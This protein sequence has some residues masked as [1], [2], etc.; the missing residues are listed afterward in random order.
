MDQLIQLKG[1]SL[2]QDCQ[3]RSGRESNQETGNRKFGLMSFEISTQKPEKDLIDLHTFGNLFFQRRLTF[4]NKNLVCRVFF[5]KKNLKVANICVFLNFASC[6]LSFN[7]HTQANKL[8]SIENQCLIYFV[9]FQLASP[10]P[11]LI[12]RRYDFINY[13]Y[14]MRN[15]AI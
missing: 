4:R 9:W 11:T 7:G 3:T 12:V 2:F 15:T 1:L 6:W 14:T 10:H 8:L 13:I 5:S